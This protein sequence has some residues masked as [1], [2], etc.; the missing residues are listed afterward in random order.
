MLYRLLGCFAVALSCYL[1]QGINEPGKHLLELAAVFV[2][3]LALAGKLAVVVNKTSRDNWRSLSAV[4]RL[5]FVVWVLSAFRNCLVLV[6]LL[7]RICF[8]QSSFSYSDTLHSPSTSLV[9]WLVV[10]LPGW[11]RWAIYCRVVRY[12][13]TLGGGLSEHE[14]LWKC[15]SEMNCWESRLKSVRVLY[16]VFANSPNVTDSCLEEDKHRWQHCYNSIDFSSF[17]RCW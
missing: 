5:N 12:R 4:D 17:T 11:G 1:R 14:W 3:D 8:V 10:S 7:S 2:N 15:T 13:L 6:S 9:T 16:V